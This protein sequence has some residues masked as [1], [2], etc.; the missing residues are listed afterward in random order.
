MSGYAT[1]SL[2]AIPSPVNQEITEHSFTEELGC[3]V[4]DVRGYKLASGA[5]VSLPRPDEQLCLPLRVDRSIEIASSSVIPAF[6]L[7]RVPAGEEAILSVQA[8]TEL[9]VISAPASQNGESRTVDLDTC[10]FTEP[11]TSTIETARLTEP[12]GL[13]GMKVN[14]RRLQPGEHVPYHTEGDQEE[15]FVPLRGP[16]SMRIDGREID[17][18]IGSVTRVAP[19]IPRS[20]V[21][22]GDRSAIWV[23]IGA[24]PTGGPS[25]WDPGAV[26][27]E[28][29]EQDTQVI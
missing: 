4:T 18:P 21:N 13:K 2:E 5:K 10:T 28:A 24:P 23:M 22:P 29:T 1:V 8:E 17:T 27:L 9:V 3:S 7:L 16:A 6:G 11:E 14:A 19:P 26:I 25:E 15:L 20:A 12:L